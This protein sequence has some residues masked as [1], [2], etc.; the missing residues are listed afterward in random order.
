MS[1]I[2]DPCRRIALMQKIRKFPTIPSTHKNRIEAMV[3][4]YISVR[5]QATKIVVRINIK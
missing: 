1:S 4:Q 3:I 5:L 2:K